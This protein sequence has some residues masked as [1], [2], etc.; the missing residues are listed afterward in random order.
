M[1]SRQAGFGKPEMRAVAGRLEPQRHLRRH[2]AASCS[3]SA[4][5]YPGFQ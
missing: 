5:F 2:L 1:A 3:K 4:S